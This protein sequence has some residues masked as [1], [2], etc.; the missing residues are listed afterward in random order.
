M[1]VPAVFLDKDGTLVEDVPYNVDP[2]RIR[3]APGAVAGLRALHAAGYLLI[4]ISNQ[5]GVARGYF[6]EAALADVE[7]RLRALL[8]EAGVPLAGFYYCPHH[9]NG[10]ISRY[11]VPCSCR[12]P[13]PGSIDRAAREHDVDLARSWFV[14]DILDDVEAGHRAGCRAILID[15]GNETEWLDAPDRR[16]DHVVADLAEAARIITGV[17]CWVSGIGGEDRD[18]TPDTRHPSP[19]LARLVDAFADLHVV[20]IGEAMLDS[21]LEGSSDRLCREAPV[22][23]VTLAARSDA[24]GG[25]ANTATNVRALGARVSYLSVLG[26]D[27]EGALLRRALDDRGVSTDHLMT[28][29]ARRTLAKHRLFAGSELL[30]RFDQ[31]STEAVDPTTEA[32]LLDR[33]AALYPRCDALVVSDYG[34]G[35]LTPRVIQLLAELHRRR[36]RPILVDSKDLTAYRHVGITVAKPNYG[37]AVRLL[38]EPQLEGAEVRV[39]QIGAAGRRMLDL[40]GSRL[41]AVTLDVDGAL[42]FERG[43]P[44]PY[45]TYASPTAH[46]RAAG[47][48][49][50]FIGAMA[51]A[52]AAGGDAP[53]AAELASAAAGVVVRKER[54][55]VC[56]ARELRAAV[57]GV[58]RPAGPLG[59]SGRAREEDDDGERRGV[60][61]RPQPA[62]R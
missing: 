9:P 59:D 23:I 62:L 13:A 28:R 46:C 32:E 6:P 15:N 14:G 49:D 31:G 44:R 57:R 50:T 8:A 54:T 42:T 60:E 51:L 37:E 26:D 55:A 38:G 48:G 27:P 39:R 41:A 53:A 7:A 35:I 45:R 47:A 56:S 21:Y 3:L 33:L 20:V 34:Y 19:N 36:P 30:V 17:G 1:S 10:A 18:P 4:V 43:A 2:E 5:S 12:K 58:G 16:P 61:P 25:A 29:S 11:A 24:P 40:T 52:L 22:P